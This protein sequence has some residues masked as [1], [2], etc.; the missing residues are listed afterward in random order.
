MSNKYLDRDEES[1]E[2]FKEQM[3]KLSAPS[4]Y[5]MEISGQLNLNFKE[6][7][8]PMVKSNLLNYFAMNL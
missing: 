7:T 5:V 6:M 2:R 3:A 8:A 4:T 1:E